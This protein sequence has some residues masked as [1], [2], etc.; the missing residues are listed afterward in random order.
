MSL[1]IL[2]SSIMTSYG[3]WFYEPVTLDEVIADLAYGNFVSAIGHESTASF[4]SLLTGIEIPV[5]R[6]MV[7]MAKGDIAIVLKLKTRL[8]EGKVLTMEELKDIPYE[9]GR[10]YKVPL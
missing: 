4:L 2:N 10:V 9:L 6:I 3:T 8:E 7:D 1:Y 5:N